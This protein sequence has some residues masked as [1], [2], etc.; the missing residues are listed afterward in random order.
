M[1]LYISRIIRD[2]NLFAEKILKIAFIIVVKIKIVC[3]Q[4]KN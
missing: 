4:S 3:V 1:Y 2:F